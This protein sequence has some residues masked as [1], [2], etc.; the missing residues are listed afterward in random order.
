MILKRIGKLLLIEHPWEYIS[1]HCSATKYNKI[2]I[3]RH[4]TYSL[5][6]VDVSLI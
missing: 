5:Y 4:C 3:R 2:R 1:I 6:N